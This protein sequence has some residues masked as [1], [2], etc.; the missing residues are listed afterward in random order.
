MTRMLQ[1]L[2]LVALIGFGSCYPTGHIADNV[3]VRKLFV[4]VDMDKDSSLSIQD[5]EGIFKRFDLNG[6]DKVESKEF[7]NY[8]AIENLGTPPE[9]VYLFYNLDVNKDGVISH[10]PDLPFIFT[11]FDSDNNGQVNEAEFV[12]TWQKLTAWQ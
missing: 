11:W 12:V 1:L 8:W 9:A 7:V 3:N 10:S 4:Q 5:F 2:F 6:D